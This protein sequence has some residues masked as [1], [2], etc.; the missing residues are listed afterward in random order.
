M[1]MG[2]GRAIAILAI[3]LWN[4]AACADELQNACREGA[5]ANFKSRLDRI[6]QQSPVLSVDAT[7]AL[8]RLEEE[9]CVRFVRCTFNDPESIRFRANFESC[10]HDEAMER[11][12]TD[13]R[14]E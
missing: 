6:Q 8:R 10:L 13:E 7:I 11:F 2:R 5:I 14:K 4:V 12:E 3:L 9:F 1:T